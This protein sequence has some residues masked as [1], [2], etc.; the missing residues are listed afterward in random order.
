V[1]KRKHS[2]TLKE[3]EA[4]SD[5]VL[6][7]DHY[8][9]VSPIGDGLMPVFA[10]IHWNATKG[11]QLR[12][13]ISSAGP[14]YRATAIALRDKIISGKVITCGENL[15]G[16][17]EQISAIEYVDKKFTFDFEAG[18]ED[19]AGRDN[20]IEVGVSDDGDCLFR[21]NSF[22]AI[23]TKIA[24]RKEDVR[25]EWPFDKTTPVRV[26]A[27]RGKKPL[28]KEYLRQHFPK[29]IPGPAFANRKA[30]K[31]EIENS[32]LATRYPQLK[33]ID[34]GTLKTAIDEYNAEFQQC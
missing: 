34:D 8:P 14:T 18:V 25:H 20:R 29:Q 21:A 19:I 2:S 27:V 33:S 28:I 30:L 4:I 13:P 12:L 10:V 32:E 11:L 31:G 16:E 1:S 23:W 7:L 15:D 6:T 5:D 9:P 24:V 22:R 3:I 26:K 17:F